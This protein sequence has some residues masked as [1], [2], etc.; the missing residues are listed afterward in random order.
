MQSTALSRIKSRVDHV[1]EVVLVAVMGIMVVNVL[2]QVFTRFVLDDPSTFTDELSRYLLIWLGLLGAAYGVSQRIHLAIDILPTRLTGE[3]RTYVLV[4]IEI[5]VALFAIFAMV[6][7][8]SQLVYITLRL[9]QISAALGIPLG[10][11]YSVIP[12]SGLLIVFFSGLFILEHLQNRKAGGGP[13]ADLLE[14]DDLA[15]YAGGT[16]PLTDGPDAAAGPTPS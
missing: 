6:V 8:G 1:L 10:Y 4:A 5:C 12:L 16:H 13:H 15:S 14:T 7:G 3:R 9:G 11:V 2:W